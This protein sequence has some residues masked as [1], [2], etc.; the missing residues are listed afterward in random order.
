MYI[1]FENKDM[2]ENAVKEQAQA[3]TKKVLSNQAQ[4]QMRAS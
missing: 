1:S 2:F 3:Q 4:L